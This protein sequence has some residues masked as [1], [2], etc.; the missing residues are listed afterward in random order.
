MSV[1]DIHSHI[2]PG[3]DDGSPDMA[4]SLA[5]AR[6]A[7]AAGITTMIGTPHG[8]LASLPARQPIRMMQPTVCPAASGMGREK[9]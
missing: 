8:S 7:V 5:M 6:L 1:V 9:I 2:L 3:L 4:T